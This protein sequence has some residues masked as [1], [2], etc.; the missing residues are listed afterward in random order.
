[1]GSFISTWI[2]LG[3][4][5][6]FLGTIVIVGILCLI[7]LIPWRERRIKL[8]NAFGT[9]A[10]SGIMRISGCDVTVRGR[11]HVAADRPA[12]Y[13]G[14]HTSIYDA[15]T[16]IWLS[17]SGTV[18]VAKKEIIYYPFY[19]IGWLLAGHLTIDRSRTDEAKA[20]MRKLGEFVKA[21]SLHL[22]MWPEGRR[23]QDGRLA[24]FK[25]GLIHMAI[26]TGLPIVP[27]VTRGAHLAWKKATLTLEKVPIDITFLPPIDTSGWTEERIEEHVAEL[28]KVFLDALPPEQ[29][30][31]PEIVPAQAA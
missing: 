9:F 26:Q 30:P 17:P 21:K 25:K 16:S 3:V 14:N 12:I 29:Q 10:G 19:G 31:L 4:G 15:F 24:P 18:G 8:T 2:R 23:S 1:L 20:S 28:R 13:A 11:E 22:F 27:M 6:V 5:L 7:P